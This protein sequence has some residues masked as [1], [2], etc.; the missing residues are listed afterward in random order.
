M[1][2]TLY[3]EYEY[4]KTRS[5]LYDEQKRS[6]SYRTKYLDLRKQM[7]EY[8]TENDI[9]PNLEIRKAIGMKL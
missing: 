1:P 3:S 2:H 8:F 7:R 4:R 6:N 9:T 5:D